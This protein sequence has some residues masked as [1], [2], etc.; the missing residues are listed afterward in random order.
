MLADDDEEQ[1][2]KE[3]EEK[4]I[5]CVFIVA[6]HYCYTSQYNLLYYL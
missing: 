3:N 2:K 1:E 6:L 4:C 5:F